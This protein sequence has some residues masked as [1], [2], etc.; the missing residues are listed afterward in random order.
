MR[1]SLLLSAQ[2]LS[3]L[4][5][6]FLKKKSQRSNSNRRP[7][8]QITARQTAASRN[9]Y[10]RPYIGL[11]ISSVP[12]NPRQPTRCGIARHY[13]RHAPRPPSR[14]LKPH[15]AP[16]KAH[17]TDMGGGASGT[18]PCVHSTTYSRG[19]HFRRIPRRRRRAQERATK[20]SALVSVPGTGGRRMARNTS[21]H[22]GPA[23]RGRPLLGFAPHPLFWL[24]PRPLSTFPHHPRAPPRR[25]LRPPRPRSIPATPTGVRPP[26]ESLSPSFRRHGSPCLPVFRP[27]WSPR[28]VL[29]AVAV[30]PPLSVTSP[31]FF[32]PL[33]SPPRTVLGPAGYPARQPLR[34]PVRYTPT[35]L[36][37]SLG[38]ILDPRHTGNIK[39]PNSIGPRWTHPLAA[40]PPSPPLSQP[41]LFRHPA[42]PQWLAYLQL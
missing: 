38:L 4:S 19:G 13:V 32:P 40:P 7:G 18:A 34:P 6:S 36:S 8:A 20:C 22:R 39:S 21:P 28:Y 9:F 31:F 29:P 17:R 41:L 14:S 16:Q 24:S 23:L 12:P 30:S 1:P 42:R 35:P 37:W 10:Q 5:F 15:P 2:F 25:F 26:K 11:Y 33:Q 3:A 27:R